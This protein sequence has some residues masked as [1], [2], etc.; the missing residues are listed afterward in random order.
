MLSMCCGLPN[1]LYEKA[2]THHQIN[3]VCFKLK[4]T[5]HSNSDIT[6]TAGWFTSGDQNKLRFL[7]KTC[8]AAKCGRW[9]NNQTE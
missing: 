4:Y 7:L 2:I 5:G 8:D 6:A 9:S 3:F 1:I